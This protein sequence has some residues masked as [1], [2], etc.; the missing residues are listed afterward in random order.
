VQKLIFYKFIKNNIYQIRKKIVYTFRKYKLLYLAHH[1]NDLKIIVGAALTAQE[2]W[3][4]TNEQWLDIT[5]EKDW[6]RFF[7]SKKIIKNILAEHVFEHLS[8][9]EADITLKIMKNYLVNG[10]KVRIAVPDGNNPNEE[11][12]KNVGIKGIGPDASDHKQLY[13]SEK[14]VSLFLKNGF[15]VDVVEGYISDG[16]L[17][18][19]NYSDSEGYVMRSRKNYNKNLN[20]N[21][22]FKDSATSLIV[23]GILKI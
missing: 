5:N 9:N 7:E 20:S 12:L 21:W 4:S 2:G 3:I 19:K 6:K 11:Y 16:R 1:A 22:G 15:E 8:E 10:G 18:Q 23:D 13:T 17:I 14:L